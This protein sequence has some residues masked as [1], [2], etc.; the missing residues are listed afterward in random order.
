MHVKIYY[1]N[2][3]PFGVL[4]GLQSFVWDVLRPIHGS[5]IMAGH[6][7]CFVALEASQFAHAKP[8]Y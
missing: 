7:H 8:C 6:G 4:L 3:R 2:R 5:A 1:E